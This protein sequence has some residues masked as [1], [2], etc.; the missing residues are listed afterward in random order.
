MEK[1][2]MCTVMDLINQK[3]YVYTCEPRIAVMCAYAQSKG[4]FVTWEYENKY[5]P[6]VLEG[7][8]TYNL[9]EFSVYKDGREF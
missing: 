8:Y 9:N 4:D 6:L 5:S 7:K 1:N 2:I 3:K